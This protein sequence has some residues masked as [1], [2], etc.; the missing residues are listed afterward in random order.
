MY[1]EKINT[2]KNKKYQEDD[3]NGRKKY[4]LLVRVGDWNAQSKEQKEILA[5]GAKL[6]TLNKMKK[7]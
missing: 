5:L 3:G 1:I 6:E 2:K 4:K 7:I